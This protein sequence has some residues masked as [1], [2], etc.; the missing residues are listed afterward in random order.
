MIDYALHFILEAT[1][2]VGCACAQRFCHHR[3]HQ[4]LVWMVFGIATT[5][6]TVRLVG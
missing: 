6:V 5:I 4:F 2:G 1:G 3:V